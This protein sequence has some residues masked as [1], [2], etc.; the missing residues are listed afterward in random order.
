MKHQIKGR[1][2]SRNSAHRKALMRNLSIALITNERIKTTLPKA[3]ELR[4]FVEK[5]LTVAKDDNLANRRLLVSILGNQDITDKLFKD[6]AP[7][8]AKR[9]RGYTRILKNGF[10]VG[11]K[12]PMAVME[13]V[14]RVEVI[15]ENKDNLEEKKLEKKPSKKIKSEQGPED[16]KAKE[17]S[18]TKSEDNKVTKKKAEKKAK[19]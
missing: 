4:P 15:A 11:D 6:I 12:A 17:N 1:K 18:E 5:I 19:E 2:L 14:D 7:R 10:R 9:N 13:L 16:S 8:I 3:K